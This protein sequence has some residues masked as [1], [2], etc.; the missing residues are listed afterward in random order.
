MKDQDNHSLEKVMDRFLHIIHTKQEY[1]SDELK[2]ELQELN[3]QCKALG[4]GCL[5]E[6]FGIKEPE[7]ETA[8]GAAIR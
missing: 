2:V 6:G 7:V 3:R 1:M 4:G 8:K 5:F